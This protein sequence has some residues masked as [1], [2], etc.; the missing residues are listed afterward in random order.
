METASDG[1]DESDDD[2]EDDEQDGDAESNDGNQ[3]SDYSQDQ[4]SPGKRK[5]AVES[6]ESN[7]SRIHQTDC[8]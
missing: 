6:G 8:S 4:T 3:D 1:S 5:S 2:D 7:F